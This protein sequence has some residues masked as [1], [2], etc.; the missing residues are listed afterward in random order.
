MTAGARGSVLALL[1]V[2][3][4][5]SAQKPVPETVMVTFR[6]KAGAETELAAV[7]ARHWTTGSALGLFESSP[8]LTLR[9]SDP[10]RKTYFVEVFTWRDAAIPDHAPPAIQAIWGDMNRLT[11]TRGGKPGLEFAEVSVVPAVE[12]PGR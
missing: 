2:A 7:I 9:G 5:G 3:A 11:E 12:L 8:H 6:A 10:D 1:V 4:V